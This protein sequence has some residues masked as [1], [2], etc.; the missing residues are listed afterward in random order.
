METTE[1]ACTSSTEHGHHVP[2]AA[3]GTED[4]EVIDRQALPREAVMSGETD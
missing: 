3:P 4:I 2:S 1:L